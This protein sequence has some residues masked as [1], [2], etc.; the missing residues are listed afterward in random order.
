MGELANWSRADLERAVTNLLQ[1]SHGLLTFQQI[2][3]SLS[4]NPTV[5]YPEM[6]ADADAPE[7]GCVLYCIRDNGS[8]KRA[9]RARFPTGAIQTLSTEP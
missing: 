8:G 6:A 5:R 4:G 7:K 1:N 2:E 9:L 3:G